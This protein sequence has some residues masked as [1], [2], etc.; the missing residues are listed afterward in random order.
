MQ[1]K[2]R[3]AVSISG[4]P[5][6][7]AD[8]SRV[9]LCR[10]RACSVACRL[11]PGRSWR[12]PCLLVRSDGVPV[13]LSEVIPRRPCAAEASGSHLESVGGQGEQVSNHEGLLAASQKKVLDSVGL[14]LGRERTDSDMMVGIG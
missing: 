1:D 7:A 12:G 4:R 9:R 14:R 3:E 8:L 11:R 10:G 5:G 13:R 6:L 2:V